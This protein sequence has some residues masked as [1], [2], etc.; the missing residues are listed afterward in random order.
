MLF[1]TCAEYNS[2]RPYRK[3]LTDKPLTNKAVQEIEFGKYLQ[4][5]IK[6]KNKSNQKVTQENYI[7]EAIY[8]GYQYRDN[9]WG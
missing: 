5:K 9:L 6:W 4:N 8:T 3:M 7:N 2:C 1:V